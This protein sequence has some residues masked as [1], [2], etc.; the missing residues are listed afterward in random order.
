MTRSLFVLLILSTVFFLC[1]PACSNRAV[2]PA[3]EAGK[4]IS[5]TT[6]VATQTVTFAKITQ[7]SKPST[8]MATKQPEPVTIW[9]CDCLPDGYLSALE[10]KEPFVIT[11]IEAGSTYEIIPTDKDEAGNGYVR[12]HWVYLL[13]APFPTVQDSVNFTQLKNTWLK[14]SWT[15]DIVNTLLVS[16]STFEVFSRL[17][18]KP[19]PEVVKI[20]PSSELLQTAWG[21]TNA[22]AIIPFE[23]IDPRWKIIRINNISPLDSNF[24]LD[25]YPLTVQFDLVKTEAG[26]LEFSHNQQESLVVPASNFVPEKLTSLIMTGTTALVRYVALKIEKNGVLYPA[27]DIVHILKDADITHISNE[28][29]FWEDCP[30]AN[31]VRLEQ[32]FC[33]DPSYFQLMEYIDADV[34]ELTGNHILDWGSEPF[35]ATLQMYQ[36]N[37]LPY[38]G[39]GRNISEAAQPLTLQDGPQSI[40][41]IGCSP[42]GPEEVWADEDSPGSNPC[43]DGWMETQVN[44]AL[45]AG[46]IPVVTFQHFEVEDYTPHSSQRIDFL[47]AA[48]MGAAIVSGSQSHFAQTMTF[49][50]DRFVHYGLGNLF[51]DQMY[52]ENPHEF[53]DR[54]YFYDGKYIST[55]LITL[56][57]EDASKPRLVT[58]SEREAFLQTIFERCNWETAFA[59]ETE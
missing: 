16:Q 54:H 57:L 23:E 20:L 32:R 50:G 22:W 14:N 41:F 28:V 43:T 56:M 51:F 15:T 58:T 24:D 29:S 49:V 34:I 26:D 6:L 39:G 59:V 31:P 1:I 4:I 11:A 27:R 3:T 36:D 35:L 38:F 52:G 25:G 53:V 44:N 33:S 17:W 10:I 13:T 55:E 8:T 9:P 21:E 45:E 47:D 2:N 5:E 18:G 30:S 19:D 37:D 7:T 42:A 40:T 48:E 46:S 12:S